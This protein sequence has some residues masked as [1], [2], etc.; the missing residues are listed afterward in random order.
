MVI[1]HWVDCGS[2][3]LP[4]SFLAG[5]VISLES[6]SVF[7]VLLF[8]EDA[9]LFCRDANTTPEAIIAKIIKAAVTIDFVFMIR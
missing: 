2:D 3:V 6:V 1:R 8:E 4:V 7:E 5:G 9:E